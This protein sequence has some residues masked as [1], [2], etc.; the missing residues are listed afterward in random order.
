MLVFHSRHAS[1]NATPD[2]WL[3]SPPGHGAPPQETIPDTLHY[4]YLLPDPFAS[5][6]TFSFGFSHFLS[7][8]AAHH[9]LQPS[10]IYI[11]TNA[12]STS[13]AVL[14]ALKASSSVSN[15]WT[16]LIFTLPELSLMLVHHP[17]PT[18][19]TNGVSIKG[20]EHKSDFVRVEA[21][22]KYGGTYIDWDVHFLRSTRRILQSGFQAI[23]GRQKYGQIN[24]GVFM[25]VAHGKMITLWKDMMHKV[26]DGGWTTHSN[27]VLTKIGERLVGSREEGEMLIMER[28]AFA[29]GGWDEEDFDLLFSP[30]EEPVLDIESIMARGW[31]L[32]DF[33]PAS[34]SE[35]RWEHP[36]RFQEWEMDWSR[37]Y[38]L[39]A[40]SPERSGYEVQGF[41]R[42]RI[43]PRYVLER[44]SNFA[45]AVYPVAKVLYERGLLGVEDLDRW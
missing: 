40:F 24:S 20:M 38:L 30:R 32:P 10:C 28:D 8:Y 3:A 17:V 4:V 27:E 18:H 14:Y 22:E 29:P 21:I 19:A 11:H 45:R 13:P 31:K 37:T 7:I 36:E 34:E 16:K 25:S 1:G 6:S 42:G 23:A 35:E 41:E 33:N 5:N 2:R 43:T 15:K 39:H 12:V 44:G 9:Y 26:Y